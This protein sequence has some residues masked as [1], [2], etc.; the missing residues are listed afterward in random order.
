MRVLLTPECRPH[1]P[2]SYISL[3]GELLM[4]EGQAL[5]LGWKILTDADG[6]VQADDD[7]T[8][9]LADFVELR[10]S[11]SRV[12]SIHKHHIQ[13]HGVMCGLTHATDDLFKPGR[14]TRT[15]DWHVTPVGDTGRIRRDPPLNA[16]EERL[17]RGRRLGCKER[18]DVFGRVSPPVTKKE[19]VAHLPEK[20]AKALLLEDLHATWH[21][22]L[23]W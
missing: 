10:L 22:D 21:Y 2:H 14:Y 12:R 16:S 8:V 1:V 15:A 3:I 19:F 9:G 23:E 5:F 18:Q 4:L 6:K 20:I 13:L 17:W 7:G 11:H